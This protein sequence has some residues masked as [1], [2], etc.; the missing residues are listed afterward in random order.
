MVGSNPKNIINN[1][2][3]LL[4][5]K[6]YYNKIAFPNN[7]YGDGYASQRIVKMLRSL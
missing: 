3:K 5:N 6:I 2:S 1:V 4:E 7:V